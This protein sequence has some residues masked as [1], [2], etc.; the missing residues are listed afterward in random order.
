MS[1]EHR[2]ARPA[3]DVGVAGLATEASLLDA[4]IDLH[5]E[6]RRD[7]LDGRAPP[8]SALRRRIDALLAAHERLVELDALLSCGAPRDAA[9]DEA[10]RS[11]GEGVIAAAE[12]PIPASGPHP[13][14]PATCGEGAP[15]DL[16]G[17][18]RPGSRI[19]RYLLTDLLGEGG[20]GSVWRAEQHEPVR[21]MVAVK[22]LKAGMDSTAIILRFR[23]EMQA[24]ASMDSQHIAKIIDAGATPLGRPYFAMELVDGQ[25][26]TRFCDDQRIDLAGR[27]DLTAQV[28][29]AIQHAH[30]KGVFHRD[31]KPQNV[32]AAM[33]DG[34]P[35][36]TI[37][38]F[39]IAKATAGAPGVATV[40]GQRLGTPAYM[41][42]EQFRGDIDID[43][44]TDVHSIG[45]LLC[46]LLA[47]ATPA[48]LA[49]RAGAGW[50]ELE[51]FVAEGPVR[52]V[53]ESL[54]RLPSASLEAIAHRRRLTPRALVA[55]LRN[56]LEWI[57]ARAT[58]PERE[59]RYATV[60]DLAE[61]LERHRSG[62]PVLAGPPA[63][64]YR[65]SK[66]VRRHRG[67]VAAAIAIVAALVLG[68]AGTSLGLARAALA[69]EESRLRMKESEAVAGFQASMLS[70][71]DPEALGAALFAS[72]VDRHAAARD[73]R[74]GVADGA[75][76]ERER[77]LRMLAGVNAT[78][79][80]SAML[81]AVLLDPAAAAL[82]T[83]EGI[84]P[85][86]AVRLRSTI[87][88]GYA[89]LGRLG[90]AVAQR[91]FALALASGAFGD[92]DIRT[93]DARSGLGEALL[94]S[95]ALDEAEL[96]LRIAER[97]ASRI[98]G[99][100]SPE[101]LSAQARLGGA[102]LSLGRVEAAAA[103]IGPARTLLIAAL[104]S[105][106]PRA[107]EANELAGALAIVQGDIEG[108]ERRHT[109]ATAAAE[110][111]WGV[112]HPR[113]ARMIGA[114]LT[115]LLRQGRVAEAEPY[116]RRALASSSRRLG[117]DHPETLRATKRLGA[118]L[119]MDIDLAESEELC[120]EALRRSRSLYGGEH[121]EAIE[122]LSNLAR[123]VQLRG[124]V[125]EALE[126]HREALEMGIARWGDGDVR[127][128]TL[129]SNVGVALLVL[130][131]LDEA[132]VELELAALGRQRVLAPEHPE[133]LQSMLILGSVR[134]ERG[135][136]RGAVN[137][138]RA[139]L[140][141]TRSASGDAHPATRDV[142]QRLASAL[143]D[144]G[145]LVEAETLLRSI[146]RDV[147]PA[148]DSPSALLAAAATDAE[149]ARVLHRRGSLDE[150]ARIGRRA[151]MTRESLRGPG[152][153]E[154]LECSVTL[155]LIDRD[156]GAA[157]EAERQLRRALAIAEDPEH[158]Q[159]RIALEIATALA[160]ILAERGDVA[161]A[162]ELLRS[163]ID[164]VEGSL[165]ETHRLRRSAADALARLLEAGS[166]RTE[167]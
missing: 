76:L 71:I 65:I 70:A 23:A 82:D 130:G 92:D 72:I 13:S 161:D 18:L 149:L 87:A 97:G 60:G 30:Q 11:D 81:A 117:D 80:A 66:F 8:G 28:C 52:G 146:S 101:Q 2:A 47:G 67:P 21:R 56:D 122:C 48:A 128:L 64:I 145:A 42:A 84:D 53:A 37:I 154:T 139:A 51:H 1:A 160:A 167:P 110:R 95:G 89:T 38:D 77:L 31:I 113:S 73:D 150:A 107:I 14:A 100:G 124:R 135:D 93:L 159:I 16:D 61:D 121:A 3:R 140:E 136:P 142:A 19:G 78:D 79:V 127:S 115:R 75:S 141:R 74:A 68:L 163:R 59:R 132:E 17:T 41:S 44:R 164:A 166:R 24:L 43:A 85:S 153:P 108:A 147:D 33:R 126:M 29:A 39:G 12:D 63:T 86:S 120:R 137:V 144:D 148:L 106:D 151:L 105:D 10:L 54:A 35:F 158:R 155:A 162:V 62:E 34:R 57:V 58:E 98:F 36:A 133:A 143:A 45:V 131:R 26:V 102:L 138:L 27:I 69:L 25:S 165:A 7:F 49:G 157:A 55:A 125:E 46:E 22:V 4:A 91:R 20:F 123:T 104:G 15:D 5:P 118:V 96:E 9:I 112:D 156:A 152:H 111:L 134:H 99:V 32:L 40:A 6:A 94:R 116:A 119:S 88:A 114:I 50:S 129:R 83:S 103:A 109:E 90:S